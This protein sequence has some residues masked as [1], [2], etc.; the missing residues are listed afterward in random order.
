[1]SK[2]CIRWQGC[3]IA[4]SAEHHSEEK[5]KSYDYVRQDLISNNEHFCPV[6]DL[7]KYFEDK[8]VEYTDTIGQRPKL[9]EQTFIKK[10]KSVKREGWTPLR[11][12]VI[13]IKEDTTMD[14]MIRLSEALFENFKMRTLQIH[15]DRDEGHW[16]RP[17]NEDGTL[18][19]K[20]VW[21]P[22]L[23]AH[24]VYD[25]TYPQGTTGE[26]T[27]KNKNGEI[28]SM[29]KD[30]SC[31]SIKLTDVQL[32]QMQTIVAQV[33]VMERGTHSD[34]KNLDAITYKNKVEEEKAV[35]LGKKVKELSVKDTDLTA[36]IQQKEN[37]IIEL[38]DT[39]SKKDDELIKKN[40]QIDE[41]N[42]SLN[43]VKKQNAE[44]KKGLK[45]NAL[46]IIDSGIL[47][48]KEEGKSE[49]MRGL[50]ESDPQNEKLIQNVKTV[51]DGVKDAAQAA[52]EKI[53][54][55]SAKESEIKL[56][57]KDMAID[58]LES[59]ILDVNGDGISKN[60]KSLFENDSENNHV[61]ENF[62]IVADGLQ[63]TVETLNNVITE[64][65]EIVDGLET[66]VKDLSAKE[67]EINGE[68]KTQTLEIIDSGILDI[69]EEG[70]SKEIRTLI[71]NDP[72][73]DNLTQNFKVVVDGVKESAQTAKELSETNTQIKQDLIKQVV[74]I[75]N[76]GILNHAGANTTN[77]VRTR[78]LNDP[79]QENIADTAMFAISKALE[80]GKTIEEK[81]SR[82]KSDNV[83]LT[84]ERDKHI[85]TSLQ[86]AGTTKADILKNEIIQA[87]D[88]TLE[89]K[90]VIDH[91][92]TRS[93]AKLL[94][95]LD[96]KP[97]ETIATHIV[98][99]IDQ[100]TEEGFQ[101]LRSRLDMDNSA[102]KE[103]I[104]ITVKEKAMSFDDIHLYTPNNKII[105]NYVPDATFRIL[106][107]ELKIQLDSLVEKATSDPTIEKNLE[108]VATFLKVDVVQAVTEALENK[109]KDLDD[110]VEKIDSFNEGMA[111][112][113]EEI[114]TTSSELSKN[115][116]DLETVKEQLKAYQD[117]KSFLD[118]IKDIKKKTDSAIIPS[119]PSLV[120][121]EN[122]FK[123]GRIESIRKKGSLFEKEDYYVIPVAQKEEYDR[124][125]KLC[126]NENKTTVDNH[127]KGAVESYKTKVYADINQI[128]MGIDSNIKQVE[129]IDPLKNEITKERESKNFYKML[130]SVYRK[131]PEIAEK[132]TDE[133]E[134]E[135]FSKGK[136]IVR[137]I[138][139]PFILLYNKLSPNILCEKAKNFAKIIF[140]EKPEKAKDIELKKKMEETGEAPVNY[141]YDRERNS[142]VFEFH[143]DIVE[144][145]I[146][147]F[148]EKQGVRRGKG[149]GI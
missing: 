28:S 76:S 85:A 14:D 21:I 55:M 16:S 59:N 19:D 40:T 141:K 22:N 126:K 129:N 1:M 145:K 84:E 48:I 99:T 80:A 54:D 139:E 25:N 72:N 82:I 116:S 30:L 125:L 2:S 137:T 38:E 32:K 45:E 56:N 58:I 112:I 34:K 119:T 131:H 115:E 138:V 101:R 124:I 15:I 81:N 50:I 7:G 46:E 68:I 23:H 12:A 69:K 43:E 49:E 31:R 134:N 113:Y 117:E 37:K 120:Y 146:Q 8:I 121:P 66:K 61:I 107:N 140:G 103:E 94:G 88:K 20:E 35:A 128:K 95:D 96:L 27:G 135:L 60:I 106:S 17:E 42:D 39:I 4:K 127:T 148:S 102:T 147:D 90:S 83:T 75:M 77:E 89:N 18:S 47:D 87:I 67:N 33:L 132:M 73:N 100:R 133:K 10:G 111:S 26:I 78:I 104:C 24:L 98:E 114:E 122:P 136:T 5:R 149:R 70:R 29:I 97:T 11:E 110:K 105:G 36:D 118:S 143:K 144:Q 13:L 6:A 44:V 64:S 108:N 71:E 109:T 92:L 91:N 74:D 9:E 3:K 51:A 123:E 57:I 41:L 130:A 93:F 142:F 52:I 53:E 79:K 65:Q 63:E 62:G 86:I